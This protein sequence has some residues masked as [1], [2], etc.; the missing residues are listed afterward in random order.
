MNDWG[1]A[2]GHPSEELAR[3]HWFSMMKKTQAGGEVEFRITVKEYAT[4]KDGALV[5]FAQADKQTNQGVAAY[6]PCGWGKT[7]LGALQ[8]CVREIN[9]F[10]YQEEDSQAAGA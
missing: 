8:E 2:Q 6:T 9:R 1:Y 5:F 10:P 3:L 4:P 7:L